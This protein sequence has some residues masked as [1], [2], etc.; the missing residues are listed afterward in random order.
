MLIEIKE[1][2]TLK[3][4]IGK[5][6]K[7]HAISTVLTSQTTLHRILR[8][9]IVDGDELTDITDEIEEGEF[10]HP[11]VV[12]DEN[13][14]IRSITVKIQELGKLLAQALLI[15]TKLLLVDQHTLL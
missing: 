11:V 5:F 4:L 8:H 9:H 6:C 12:V 14:S 3:E 1:V 15:V 2:I 10:L 7:R 13:S